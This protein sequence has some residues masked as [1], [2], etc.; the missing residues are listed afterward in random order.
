MAEPSVLPLASLS[1]TPQKE[2]VDHKFFHA[3]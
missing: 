1:A 2:F 3:H